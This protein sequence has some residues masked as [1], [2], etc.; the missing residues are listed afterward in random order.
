[1]DISGKK[2]IK[3]VKVEIEDEGEKAFLVL[4]EP[5]VEEGRR[6][7]DGDIVKAFREVFPACLIEHSFTYEGR[8]ATKEELLEIL[9]LSQWLFGQVIDAWGKVLFFKKRSEGSSDK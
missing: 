7:S 3:S 1:M 8:P 5:T 6:F 2:Y 4:R 9:L